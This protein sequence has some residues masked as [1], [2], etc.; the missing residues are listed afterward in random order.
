M[1]E[2][3]ARRIAIIGAGK[4]GST[5]G[6]R[7]ADAGHNV[8][9]GVRSPDNPKHAQLAESVVTHAVAL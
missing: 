1:D 3:D 4:V 5:L 9:Y 7:F 6:G 8:I 2:N